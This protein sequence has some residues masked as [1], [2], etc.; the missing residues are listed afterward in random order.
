M[1]SDELADPFP[2]DTL[3]GH[4]V[5]HRA[6]VAPPGYNPHTAHRLK[7]RNGFALLTC[8]KRVGPDGAH[9]DGKPDHSQVF[10]WSKDAPTSR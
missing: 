9:L 6:I 3:C 2:K 8:C 1:S 4:Q 7:P 10:V 5:L